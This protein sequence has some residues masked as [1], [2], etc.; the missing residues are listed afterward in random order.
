[1]FRLAR[2]SGSVDDISDVLRRGY[3]KRFVTSGNRLPLSIHADHPGIAC[4]GESVFQP[5]LSQDA[6]DLRIFN[7]EAE[8]RT[9]M[10]RIERHVS[11]AG[12]EN[13]QDTDNCFQRMF[14]T[15]AGVR[16]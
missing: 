9:W 12:F 8:A 13:G 10:V 5:L 11:G 1:A 15:D 4:N 6:T 16:A 3:R 14:Q 7:Y 2:R